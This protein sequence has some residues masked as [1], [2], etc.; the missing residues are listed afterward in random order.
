MCDLS[1]N[2]NDYLSETE[3]KYLILSW[4]LVGKMIKELPKENKSEYYYGL[5][6]RLTELP[7]NANELRHYLATTAGGDISYEKS[8]NRF[9]YP[10]EQFI[11]DE[12]FITNWLEKNK[13]LL[14]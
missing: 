5:L 8:E 3:E 10:S 1:P 12:H 9:K 2:H 4:N 7:A 11:P 6:V 14:E 13:E